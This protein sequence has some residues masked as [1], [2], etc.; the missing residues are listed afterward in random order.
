[1]TVS[2]PPRCGASAMGM[3]DSIELLQD[4]SMLRLILTTVMV[5]APDSDAPHLRE[6]TALCL[7][8]DGTRLYV[9]NGRS[10]SLSIIDPRAARVVSQHSV[11]R[12]L[13]DLALLPDGRH[14]LAVDRL[15]D[16]VL[17]LEER[18][19]A[20]RVIARQSVAPDPVS[21]V[22]AGDGGS[23]V[24][25]SRWSRSLTFLSRSSNALAVSKTL[26]L[27]FSPKTLV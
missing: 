2:Y 11:G 27:P 19:D 1:M 23:C 12:A 22:V 20:V 3:P 6:P 13:A 5:F 10:G 17:L 15:A 25:A 8:G 16:A 7:S 9:A 21:V 4:N 14:L 26:A 18:D 24:V